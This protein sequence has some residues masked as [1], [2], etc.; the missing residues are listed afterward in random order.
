MG[1]LRFELGSEVR[2]AVDQAILIFISSEGGLLQTVFTTAAG[3]GD[4]STHIEAI[5][6]VVTVFKD[7]VGYDPAKLL[8]SVRGRYGQY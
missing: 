6:D 4:P 8:A 7:G 3:A 1:S 5:E 2:A